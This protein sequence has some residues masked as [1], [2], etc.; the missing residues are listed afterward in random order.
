MC[1]LSRSGVQ[2]IGEQQDV[3]LDVALTSSM[4]FPGQ[5]RQWLLATLSLCSLV[6]VH[7]GSGRRMLVM[8]KLQCIH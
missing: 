8:W 3:Y 7:Q 2:L 5:A 1:L 6:R 4:V